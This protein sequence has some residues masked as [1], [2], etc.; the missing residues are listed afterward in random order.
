LTLQTGNNARV[1]RGVRKGNRTDERSH[2][3][4]KEK[5]K[6]VPER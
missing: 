6:S 5:K 3:N 4:L 2:M 1:G